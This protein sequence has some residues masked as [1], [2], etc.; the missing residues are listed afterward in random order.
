M[1]FEIAK[2]F[3]VQAPA[4]RVWE[5][6][7]DPQRVAQCLPG[8]AV[9][10]KLDEK[11]WAGT[12]SVK[13][14]PV[15][16]SYKGQVVFESLDA[17]ARRAE[18]VARG[19]DTKGKGGADLRLTSTLSEQG[20][21]ATQVTTVSRVNVTGILAQM[22]RGMIQD[23]SDQMF[24]VFS[25]RMRAELERPSAPPAD[26]P[27]SPGPAQEAA[28]ALAAP[29]PPAAKAEALDLGSIGAR[30][31]LRRPGLWIAAAV[32]LLGLYLLFRR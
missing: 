29:P 30:A 16:S 19:T 28:P 23:V 11:T 9:T 1:A 32:V 21:S 5:F 22:G 4:A 3:V 6:L 15:S 26:A 24:Q 31:A 13:V 10:Q 17:G 2:T 27:P 8:A 7:V 18:I 12:M 14:G 25:Q 20:P